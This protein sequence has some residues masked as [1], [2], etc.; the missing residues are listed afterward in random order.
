MGSRSRNAAGPRHAG[1]NLAGNPPKFLF[2]NF[3]LRRASQFGPPGGC[4]DAR[5]I[6]CESAPELAVFSVGCDRSTV[7]QIGNIGLKVWGE[8][9]GPSGEKRR[10]GAGGVIMRTAHYGAAATLATLV[11]IGVIGGST[12]AHQSDDGSV[13][14]TIWV[15]N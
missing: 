4:F 9:S 3:A 11:G 7:R 14:G 8:G 5:S 15:A 6:R 13:S 12:S 10:G 1:V 2:L